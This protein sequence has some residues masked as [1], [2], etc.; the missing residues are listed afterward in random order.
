M[1]YRSEKTCSGSK[2]QVV[3]LGSEHSS[4]IPKPTPFPTHHTDN[5]T[6]LSCLMTMDGGKRSDN[7]IISRFLHTHPLSGWFIRPPG[8][9]PT[10]LVPCYTVAQKAPPY[11]VV[12]VTTWQMENPLFQLSEETMVLSLFYRQKSGQDSPEASPSPR[13]VLRIT[14][15]RNTPCP[16]EATADAEV[17]F[18]A[19]LPWHI[20]YPSKLF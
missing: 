19:I 5:P 16:T 2:P 11:P 10:A 3:G 13:R 17:L 15:G 4:L 18:G 9:T 1:S 12:P 6:P 7:V 20:F 14:S 8:A